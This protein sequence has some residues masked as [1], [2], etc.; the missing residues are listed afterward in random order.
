M[1]EIESRLNNM[2]VNRVNS[3]NEFSTADEVNIIS[4][5]TKL[6]QE[7]EEDQLTPE[8][9]KQGIAAV[10]SVEGLMTNQSA[11]TW[12]IIGL[13]SQ[14]TEPE[15]K[16]YSP[17][18]PVD[19]YNFSAQVELQ[20][21]QLKNQIEFKLCFKRR[22]NDSTAPPINLGQYPLVAFVFVDRSNLTVKHNITVIGEHNIDHWLDNYDTCGFGHGTSLSKLKL[23]EKRFFINNITHVQVVVEDPDHVNKSI[24]SYNGTLRW[25]IP[26]YSAKVENIVIGWDE[27]L[28]S[29]SFY[30]SIPGYRLRI[31][32]KTVAFR[33]RNVTALSMKVITGKWD[34]VVSKYLYFKTEFL[35]AESS[36]VFDDDIIYFVITPTNAIKHPIPSLFP[37]I[38]KPNTRMVNDTGLISVKI[39]Q[40]EPWLRLY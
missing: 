18:F 38:L 11:T 16:L 31:M 8:E 35:K 34:T 23:E 10:V 40:I 13:Q 2:T 26:N 32:L 5:I 33:R 29:P 36:F 14:L 17:I 25:E 30:T 22:N 3:S 9:R 19:G 28:Y 15:G 39:T 7:S 21:S 1:E 24:Y 20:W 4:S 27:A 6:Q 12:E 37:N